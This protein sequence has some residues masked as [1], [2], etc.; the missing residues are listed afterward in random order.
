VYHICL[1]S[2]RVQKTLGK[3]FPPW[4]KSSRIPKPGYGTDTYES[5]AGLYRIATG[6]TNQSDA[7][8]TVVGT[9]VI[10]VHPR[11]MVMA[12]DGYVL[13]GKSPPPHVPRRRPLHQ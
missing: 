12:N 7:Q 6:F 5:P 10:A 2:K 4:S 1:E 11:C 3:V 9:K 8:G 13:Q